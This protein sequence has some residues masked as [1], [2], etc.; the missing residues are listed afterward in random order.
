MKYVV[1]IFSVLQFLHA[2]A[3][4]YG[5]STVAG[6]APSAGFSG[7]GGP[8]TSAVFGYPPDVAFD[9]QNNLYIT[10]YFNSR[11]RKVDAV[12]GVITT[13][14]GGGNPTPPSIGDGGPA[15]SAI[16]HGPLGVAVDSAG[17][18]FVSELDASRVRRIDALT[19]TITTVAGTGTGGFSGDG[20]AATAAMIYYPRGLSLDAQGNLY[21]ADWNNGRIRKVDAATGIITT[22]AGGGSPPSIGDGGPATAAVLNSPRDVAS[23]AQGNLYIAD[24]LHYRIRRVDAGTGIITT[25]AGGGN[26]V[27]PSTGE[28]GPAT[29]AKINVAC[30]TVDNQG[31]LFI[32][33]G[34]RVY[35]VDGST[36]IINTIAGSDTAGFGGDG[37]NAITAKLTSPQG[38]TADTQGNVYVTDYGNNRVRKLTPCSITTVTASAPAICAGEG[39]SLSITGLTSYT[40][41]SGTVNSVANVTPVTTITYSVTG[42]DSIGCSSTSTLNIQVY[43]LPTVSVN[44][45]TLC[46]GATEPAVLVPAGAATYS[47]TGGSFTVNPAATTS[48]SVSGTDINGCASSNTAVANVQVLTS[49]PNIGITG[50][51]SICVN[52]TAMLSVQG[53]N[54]YT[55]TFIS[56]NGPMWS[57]NSALNVSPGVTTTY[58]VQGT[59]HNGCKSDVVSITLQVNLC[60]GMREDLE[61]GSEVSVYPNPGPG[62]FTVLLRNW[63]GAKY[64]LTDISGSVILTGFTPH[65]EFTIDI[66]ELPK[67]M[68][69]FKVLSGNA[70][71]MNKILKE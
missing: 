41:S 69:F 28:G 2:G 30:V 31:N 49:L 57:Y 48:Y 5:I 35:K 8:A 33:G 52:E 58:S 55:W 65:E 53:A 1:I 59:D 67:G 20:G 54:T 32:G 63:A 64:E 9:K 71:K 14:A 24:A 60:T 11:L 4:K 3:Q 45:A 13:I 10:D 19:G 46:Y 42:F 68:Y 17:N 22:V 15:T 29:S 6:S 21:I 12:T 39:T 66:Q 38:I 16:L 7:D 56:P 26:P 34:S 37:G 62:V 61:H 23:D 50:S 47:I 43:P 51:N 36:T 18:I 25:V 44:S 70:V 40:W 27:Y